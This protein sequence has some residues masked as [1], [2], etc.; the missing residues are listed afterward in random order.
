MLKDKNTFE[1][2]FDD[3]KNL[4][5]LSISFPSFL[6]LYQVS[7][8]HTCIHVFPSEKRKQLQKLPTSRSQPRGLPTTKS[9]MHTAWHDLLLWSLFNT[10][11][12]FCLFDTATQTRYPWLSFLSFVTF[13]NRKSTKSTRKEADQLC[14][15]QS[16]L[17]NSFATMYDDMV[18]WR[19]SIL[20][21]HSE[22]AFLTLN[23]DWHCFDFLE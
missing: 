23:I 4:Y 19:V 17:L 22:V 6:K 14:Q 21:F 15:R 5:G 12:Y 1:K 13:C 18:W 3:C 9:E 8:Q 11:Q 16:L 7:K 20:P 10:V 2:D